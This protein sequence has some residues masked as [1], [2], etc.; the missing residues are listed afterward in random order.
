MKTYIDGYASAKEYLYEWKDYNGP[1]V[2]FPESATLLFGYYSS[3]NYTGAAFA[4]FE[5]EGKL[6]EVNGYHCSCYGLEGQ[7]KPEETTS[8]AIRMRKWKDL[9]HYDEESYAKLYGELMLVLEDFEN[10]N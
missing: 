6:Y 2:E 3:M 7:W 5:Y 4:L 8:K 10:R 9:F 1:D